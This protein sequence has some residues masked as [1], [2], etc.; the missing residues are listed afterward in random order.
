M[1]D[2]FQVQDNDVYVYWDEAVEK[3]TLHAVADSEDC[4]R[5]A[6]PTRI[7]VV[8]LHIFDGEGQPVWQLCRQM[9]CSDFCL[10]AVAP[11]NWDDQ[12]TPWPAPPVFRKGQPFG[13]HADRQLALLQ[14]QVMPQTEALLALRL[15]ARDAGG[16]DAASQPSFLRTIAGYS[17]AGLFAT[18][19]AFNCDAFQRVASASG[20]LWYPDFA[21]YACQH[22]LSQSVE[23]MYFSVGADEDKGRNRAMRTVRT[24]TERIEAQVE[25]LGVS[26]TFQ[27]NPGNHFTDPDGRMARGI[28]WALGAGDDA[29]GSSC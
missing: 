20:S 23:R 28:C 27:L 14:E 13:G 17:L 15:S 1:R 8:Y 26:S 11:R 21:D 6:V 7:N 19:A 3:N 22:P 2:S 16:Q 25:S 29:G 9:G 12:M 10:V 4:S 24:A 5:T 18:W